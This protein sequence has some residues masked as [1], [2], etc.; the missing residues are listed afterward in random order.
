MPGRCLSSENTEAY[1]QAVLEQV[2]AQGAVC[3]NDLPP[4]PAPRKPKAGDWR[5]SIARWALEH[6]F[7]KGRLTVRA[8]KSN[9]Q[10]I[11]D[12]PERVIPDAQLQA[13]ADTHQSQRELL[14]MAAQSCGVAA[15]QDLADYFRMSTRDA[16]PRIAELVEE[17]E[18][19]PVNVEGWDTPAWLAKDARIPRA[20]DGASLLSPF[21]PVVWYRP[22]AQRLFDF[23]YRIEIY[24]PAA[25]RKWGYYVLPFRIGDDI[26]ARVDLKADRKERRLLVQDAHLEADCDA[27]EVAGRLATELQALAGWLALDEVR[28][29]RRTKFCNCLRQSLRA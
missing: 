28:V 26:V 27:A 2:R 15:L 23:H 24:V 16:E 19:N 3:A 7:G 4:V 8:R 20:I 14:R 6:H 29:R 1:L 17:G 5:R 9:F 10:R 25:R 18:L 12:L 13:R 22:R 11:Y 21:D